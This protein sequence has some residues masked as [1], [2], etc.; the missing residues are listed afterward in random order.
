MQEVMADLAVAHLKGLANG[1]VGRPEAE[2]LLGCR[3][4]FRV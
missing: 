3:L 2:L 1:E 4:G